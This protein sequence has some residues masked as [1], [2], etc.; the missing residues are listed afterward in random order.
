MDTSF[1]AYIALSNVTVQGNLIVVHGTICHHDHSQRTMHTDSHN[2]VKSSTSTVSPHCD[3]GRLDGGALFQ[4]GSVLPDQTMMP[5]GSTVYHA[6]PITEI[7]PPPALNNMSST[8]QSP[9]GVNVHS[10][11][12]PLLH[13]HPDLILPINLCPLTENQ[14]SACIAKQGFRR[15]VARAILHLRR[16]FAR[17]T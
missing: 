14:N 8:N 1:P 17:F 9:E 10:S 4:E 5:G 15:R 3:S 13:P 11:E 16:V 7:T 2:V 12:F 6:I